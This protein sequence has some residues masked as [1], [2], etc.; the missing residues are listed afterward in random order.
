MAL[1][2]AAAWEHNWFLSGQGISRSVNSFSAISVKL[3]FIDL[4]ADSVALRLE[5]AAAA[6]IEWHFYFF[7]ETSYSHL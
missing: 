2:G 1:I 5:C 3:S 7:S 6:D 4:S